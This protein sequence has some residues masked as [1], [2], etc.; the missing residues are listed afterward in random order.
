MSGGDPSDPAA[1]MRPL[2]DRSPDSVAMSS[3]LV[4]RYANAACAALFGAA[5]PEELC[6]LSALDLI[7]PSARE[8]ILELGRRRASGE[9]VPSC[10]V[11]QGRRRDG[12]EFPV[13]IRSLA[14][15]GGDH[16]V[17]THRDLTD[18]QAAAQARPATVPS[19]ATLYRAVFDVNTAIKLLIDPVSGRIVDANPAALAFYGWPLEVLRGMAIGDINTATADELRAEMDAAVSGRRGCFRFRHRV[20]SGEVRHVEV[21]S[22]P[23]ELGDHALLM[24]II[25]DVTE[26]DALEQHLRESQ[27]LEA[28]GRLAGG[29]AHEFNNLLTV[30]LAASAALLRRVPSTWEHRAQLEDIR[31]ASERAAELTRELLAFSRRQF[32]QPRALDLNAT[33][34]ELLG[35]LQRTFGDAAVLDATLTPNLPPA[36]VDPRQLEHV[37]MN[38]VINARD[39]SPRGGRIE[40]T[41]AVEEIHR[42]DAGVVPAGRWVVLRVRDHGHGMDE[43]TRAR[44]FEPMF[45]TKTPGAGTGLGMATVYG[46]V[47]QGGGHITVDSAPG[48]GTEVAVFLPIAT[49]VAASPPVPPPAAPVAIGRRVLVVDDLD[50]VRGALAEGLRELGYEVLEASSAAEALAR[51]DAV[52][53]TIDAVVT[54]NVMPGRSGVDLVVDLLARRPGLPMILMSGD[55]RGQDLTRLAPEVRL[56]AKPFTL[57]SLGDQL[58]ALLAPR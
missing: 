13:E 48:V 2:F 25:H 7:A 6:G 43:A 35:V 22:G 32:L 41:T 9:P 42:R 11:S 26:R 52:G 10:Y 31:F 56:L 57:D 37:V 58:A 51:F 30:T 12:R 34:G 36:N 15:L 5:S 8:L 49:M 23:I 44:M 33:I 14:V 21:Y 17:V 46:I 3:N 55:L 50:P 38:L 39:A 45:T 16:V 47:T 19:D 20:A 53:A 1:L 54:D 28:V 18:E 27:R 29:I 40:I 4:I 24:S